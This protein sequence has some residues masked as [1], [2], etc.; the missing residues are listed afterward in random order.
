MQGK[1]RK[2]V[3]I[4]D[5]RSEA[6]SPNVSL[7]EMSID[8]PECAPL[9][10]IKDVG[11]T[12]H[13]QRKLLRGAETVQL[14]KEGKEEIHLFLELN[15]STKNERVFCFALFSFSLSLVCTA[16]SGWFGDHHRKLTEF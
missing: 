16:L 8:S 4:L 12:C 11:L 6:Y 3:K 14:V 10:K 15:S 9:R 5:T 13:L 1:F 7:P 2:W